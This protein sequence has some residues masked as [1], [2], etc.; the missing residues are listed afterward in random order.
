MGWKPRIF[1]DVG[2]SSEHD[3]PATSWGLKGYTEIGIGSFVRW[4]D[5]DL[6][7]FPRSMGT[8]TRKSGYCITWQARKWGFHQQ[9]TLQGVSLQQVVSYYIYIYMIIC[10]YT[11]ISFPTFLSCVSTR[12][13]MA[14]RSLRCRGN[15]FEVRGWDKTC[16]ARAAPNLLNHYSITIITLI[17]WMVA[18][19]CT[20]W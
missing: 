10:I 20:S 11:M 19:S 13:T 8:F 2:P 4:Q 1:W 7:K 15:R 5:C 16:A 3:D 12:F 14:A 6:S 18:K 17:Q 9:V